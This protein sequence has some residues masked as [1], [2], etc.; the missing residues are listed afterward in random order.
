MTLKFGR[1]TLDDEQEGIILI[2][3]DNDWNDNFV[4][5]TPE[6]E[7]R[8]RV[9]VANNWSELLFDRSML[10]RI[11]EFDERYNDVA[12][13]LE[14]CSTHKKKWELSDEAKEKLR[15]ARKPE[16]VYESFNSITAIEKKLGRNNDL[17][18]DIKKAIS[19]LSFNRKTECIVYYR[20]SASGKEYVFLCDKDYFEEIQT[21]NCPTIACGTY[22]YLQ[23]GGFPIVYMH[24]DILKRYG[25]K[26]KD[27][28]VID[29]WTN[30]SVDNRKR[31]LTVVSSSANA[32]NREGAVGFRD[33]GNGNA[34]IRIKFMTKVYYL[35]GY[36]PTTGAA[37]YEYLQK[38]YTKL[39][40]VFKEGKLTEKDV[41]SYLQELPFLKTL[42]ESKGEENDICSEISDDME[43]DI[44]SEISDDMED[45]ICSEISDDDDMEDAMKPD[46]DERKPS[47][48]MKPDDD[49]RKPSGDIPVE[50]DDTDDEKENIRPAG[51]RLCRLRDSRN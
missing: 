36:T 3:D 40:T 49:E 9:R 46:D 12:T 38:H 20:G 14:F 7:G 42:K 23:Y 35:C 48:D 44:C 32:S 5:L 50:A 18:V 13:L 17:L 6:D 22:G 37:G 26:Y 33:D 8:E 39:E 15:E 45:D 24:V 34:S 21:K 4:R 43:D 25:A 30:V 16:N 1:L 11:P 10:G 27:G 31:N 29:H 28:C 51:K 19:R 2:G 47:S 41:Q